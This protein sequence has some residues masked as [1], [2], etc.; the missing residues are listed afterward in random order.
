MNRGN[1]IFKMSEKE[2]WNENKGMIP[3]KH[4]L[5]LGAYWSHIGSLKKCWD[6]R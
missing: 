3:T 5:M 2:T 4:T 6:E 1:Q